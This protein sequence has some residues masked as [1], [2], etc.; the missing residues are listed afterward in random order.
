MADPLAVAVTLKGHL[1]GK[2][3]VSVRLAAEPA[4]VPEREPLSLFAGFG[5][6]LAQVPER[7]VPD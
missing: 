2:Y 5:N 3:G 7:A 4:T 1:F 6:V